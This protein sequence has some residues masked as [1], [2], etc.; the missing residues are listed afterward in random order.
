MLTEV[1]DG[2]IL[3]S[4]S[5]GFEADR[6]NLAAFYCSIWDDLGE[7]GVKQLT[8]W[9][10]DLVSERHPTVTLDDIWV[11]VDPSND[12]QIVSALL[13]IPQTW[14]YEEVEFTVGRIELIATHPDYRR[15]GLVRALMNTAHKRSDALGHLMQS[16]TGIPYYYRQFGYAV[17]VDLGGRSGLNFSAVP[18]R[19]DDQSPEF[20][21]R[22]ATPDDIPNLMCWDSYYAQQ[23][24]LTTVRD[25][26]AWRYEL[27][28]RS[29]TSQVYLHVNIITDVQGEGVGYVAFL[30]SPQ[31]SLY[32]IF[33]YVVGDKS[34]YLA[35]FDDVMRGIQQHAQNNAD[36]EFIRIVFDSGLSVAVDKLVGKL[37]SGVV[38]DAMYAWY[39]RVPEL[40]QFVDKIKPVLERRL[41]HSV[42]H[43]Y[44]GDLKIAFF[45]M[46]GLFIKFDD[47]CINEVSY[48]ALHQNDAHAAFPYHMFLNVLFGHRSIEQMRQLMPD[49]WAKREA[50]LL[51]DV[52][53]PQKRSWLMA[54]A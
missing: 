26:T 6:A 17:A 54:L 33:G 43:R 41:H 23:C 49:V 45:D 1:R 44:T 27:V 28:E 10:G 9:T 31:R 4:L 50:T 18:K 32:E 53:F 15:R 5:E 34:S 12:E 46:T 35:T 40:A 7:L 25:E 19:K 39:L 38:R 16:I 21:L 42:A 22:E 24:L 8:A 11:V 48:D 51:M 14:R 2:L 3:R 52:L 29:K 47:G 20:T 36:G 37:T 13:L 30:P